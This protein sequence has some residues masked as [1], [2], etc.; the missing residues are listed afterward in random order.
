MDIELCQVDEV[1]SDLLLYLFNV[2][3]KWF[4]LLFIVLL[5]QIGLQLDVV[6]VI[7]VGVVIEMIYLVIFY[8][9][10]VMDEVQVC[11]GV[12]SVNV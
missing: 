1:M 12:F 4:C 7:V 2:G 5:V 11:C 3:G 8:Y 10:D 6:V 9:D